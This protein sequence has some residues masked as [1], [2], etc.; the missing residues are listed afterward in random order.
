[1]IG[2]LPAATCPGGWQVRAAA[3]STGIE[4]TGLTSWDVDRVPES[5]ES[6][7]GVQGYPALVDTGTA[8]DPRA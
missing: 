5:F 8:V 1:M 6:G 3:A 2:T 4:R 7:S